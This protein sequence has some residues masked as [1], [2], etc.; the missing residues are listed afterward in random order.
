MVVYDGQFVVINGKWWSMMI[1]PAANIPPLCLTINS[2]WSTIKYKE[3]I[4]MD[5]SLVRWVTGAW[6][7]VLVCLGWLAVN[8]PAEPWQIDKIGGQQW[9]LPALIMVTYDRCVFEINKTCG[10][11]TLQHPP[12][13]TFFLSKEY[14]IDSTTCLT[15]SWQTP[16]KCAVCFLQ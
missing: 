12:R 14:R 16:S 7:V 9:C 2:S 11:N 6:M 10:N 15:N 1:D 5:L 8:Q 3:V 13:L 4:N